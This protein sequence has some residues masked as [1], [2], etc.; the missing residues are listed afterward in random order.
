MLAQ[1]VARVQSRHAVAGDKGASRSFRVCMAATDPSV[2][3][4]LFLVD[5]LRRLY[6]MALSR[7]FHGTHCS[8]ATCPSLLFT[9]HVERIQWLEAVGFDS[10][11]VALARLFA[12]VA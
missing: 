9:S 5:A 1:R 12:L 4:G 8:R 3:N 11:C 2:S 10:G 6:S 7:D